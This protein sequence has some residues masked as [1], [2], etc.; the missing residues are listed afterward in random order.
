MRFFLAIFFAA[1]LWP[2]S[3]QARETVYVAGLASNIEQYEKMVAEKGGNPFEIKTYNSPYA[4]RPALALLIMQQALKLGGMDAQMIFA[5]YPNYSRCITELKKGKAT[6]LASDIWEEQFDETVYKT[7]PFIRKGEF[8]K[9]IYTYCSPKLLKSRPTLNSLL[10]LRP[11]TGLSWTIDQH[12]FHQMGYKNI[13][14]APTYPLLFKM[15]TRKR[16]DYTLLEFPQDISH[17]F[18][19]NNNLRLVEGVKVVFPY[20]RHFMVSKKHPEGAKVFKALQKGLKIMRKNGDIDRA[21]HQTRIIN[22]QVKN[23]KI[24]WPKQDIKDISAQ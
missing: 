21:L 22:E 23:W 3:L 16:A 20:S 19:D 18:I 9:G 14:I 7:I 10:K 13:E 6:I 8:V 15:L 1:M 4:S 17:Q 24:L 2:S 5:T 12:V 11:I